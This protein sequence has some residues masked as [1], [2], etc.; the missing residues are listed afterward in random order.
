ML[1]LSAQRNAVEDETEAGRSVGERVGAST[2][3]PSFRASGA[4]EPPATA[5]AD[6]GAAHR[7]IGRLRCDPYRVSRISFNSRSASSALLS[8]EYTNPFLLQ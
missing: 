1:T 8:T 4:S 2:S 6:F 3:S 7:K 5:G